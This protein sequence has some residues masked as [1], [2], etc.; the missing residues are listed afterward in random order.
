MMT[1]DWLRSLSRR[2]PPGHHAIDV[3]ALKD[4]VISTKL[5]AIL[6]LK[7]LGRLW[8]LLLLPIT[9]LFPPRQARPV[10]K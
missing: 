6:V 7:V 5:P 3:S 2:L 10:L 9:I 4:S 8:L 1:D